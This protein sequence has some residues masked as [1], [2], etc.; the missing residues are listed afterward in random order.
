[1]QE[2]L[3][4]VGKESPIALPRDGGRRHLLRSGSVPRRNN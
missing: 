2:K 3:M 1:V 4:R